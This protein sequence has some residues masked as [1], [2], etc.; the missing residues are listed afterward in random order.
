MQTA[1][2]HMTVPDF[3]YMAF[4]DLASDLGCSG[5]EVRNDIKQK[6]FDG[7][8]PCEAGRIASDKGLRIFGLSQVYPFNDWSP[9]REDAVKS[10]I[11]IAK[12]SSAETI[13]LIPLN[14]GQVFETGKRQ[15][16]LLSALE[17]VLL[18]LKDADMV[19]LIEPLGFQRSSLRSKTEIVEMIT[20]IGGNEHLRIVHDTFHHT[21][22][23]GGPIYPEMTG[24]VHISGVSDPDLGFMHME[25][26]HR[27]LVDAQDRIGNVEQIGALIGAGYS[28]P[29]SFECFSPKIHNLL[30][31]FTEIKKSFEY[32]SKQIQVHIGT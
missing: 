18:L 22:A 23:D 17:G 15:S 30:N 4:L 29:I 1:L 20:S 26:E 11:E 24:I 2:N 31:P 13:S 7:I 32:I 28:G 16:N 5:V 9:H 6:L 19:G 14:N 3:G 27:V 25:D 8:E 21:L 12:D 10:L